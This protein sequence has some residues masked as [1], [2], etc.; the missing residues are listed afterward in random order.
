L[1]KQSS[2]PEVRRRRLDQ[3]EQIYADAA[4][5]ARVI[6]LVIHPYIVGA[7]HRAADVPF[8]TGEQIL[9]RFL[10]AGPKAP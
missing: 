1:V 7:P 4:D 6:A 10:E 9:D 8:W 5:P 3:F 2:T